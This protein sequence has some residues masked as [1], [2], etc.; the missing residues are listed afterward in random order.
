MD[1]QEHNLPVKHDRRIER[2]IGVKNGYALFEK[3]SAGMN[4]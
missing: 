4:V 2:Y 1:K 3:I